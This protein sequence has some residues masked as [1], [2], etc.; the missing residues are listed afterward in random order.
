[1]KNQFLSRKGDIRN[2][3]DLLCRSAKAGTTAHYQR[4]ERRDAEL[5]ANSLCSLAHARQ[6]AVPFPASPQHLRI[7]PAAVV[8][9]Q[10]PQLIRSIL[11]LRLDMLR[12]GVSKSVNDSLAANPIDLIADDE[13]ATPIS[14]WLLT[15]F[16][17]VCDQYLPPRR[18]DSRHHFC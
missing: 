10:D 1:M 3:F 11:E 14:S 5:P 18:I 6:S 16:R 2:F 12:S 13:A 9:H 7:D 8:A 15:G 17:R 4:E